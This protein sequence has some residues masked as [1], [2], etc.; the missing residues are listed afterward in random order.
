M[1]KIGNILHFINRVDEDNCGDRVVCPLLHYYDYFSQYRVMRHDMRFVDYDRITSGDVVIIGGGGMFNYAE[2][3]NR[4][5][6]RVLDTGATV[7]A[8]SPGFNTHT[9][10]CGTFKTEIDFE[11]FAFVTVRDFQNSYGLGYLPDVTCK[12]Q[13]LEKQY[14]IKREFG[15]ARHKDYPIK[16]LAF[17]TI[18]NDQKLEDILRFIGES[19]VVVS[20]SFHM[21]YWALLMGKRTI[22]AQP[23]S[24]K[25]YSYKYKPAYYDPQKDKL[26]DCVDQAQTYRILGECRA[27]ND[28]FFELVKRVVEEKLTP[29]RD[30]WYGYELITQEA[31]Q[32]EKFRETRLQ[33]GDLLASQLF[34]DTG[35]GF[36]E[37]CKLAS[38]N[39]V[40]GDGVHSVRF[41]LSAF[42]NIRALRFDPIESHHCE[43]EIRS[44]RA[45]TGD[46]IM[47]P[48]ASVRVGAWDRFL[49]TDP[50]YYIPA[51]CANF[52]EIKFCLRVTT[53]FEAEQ[54]IYDYVGRR[55]EAQRRLEELIEQRNSQIAEQTLRLEQQDSWIGELTK[56][57]GRLDMQLDDLT[58]ELGVRDARLS[59]M[60]TELEKRNAR[61]SSMETDLEMRNARISSLTDEVKARDAQLESLSEQ[62]FQE[63][64][65]AARQAEVIQQ[66]YHSRSWR[67]TAPFR[68]IV[69]FFRTFM[70]D[71]GEHGT[72]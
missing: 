65:C 11:R 25:F 33:D 48:Q 70:K 35:S 28:R 54:N 18:T 30:R 24:T 16:G 50:Q 49:S 45:E 67:L 64:T 60:E 55:D 58:A 52:L 57:L 19:E 56:H 41:D 34:I 29:V 36:S 66:L 20:N 2:F 38:I 69:N 37:S 6:N 42:D 26:Q 10:Y 61:L 4:A 1:L 32:R 44:A 7:L 53:L 17:D 71:G 3:T 5:I 27:E 68:A 72:G 46:V 51:P 59:S 9:E 22:C 8:W 31:L 23:F 14:G 62:L 13:G 12:L 21:I 39:N 63:H 47:Q 43:V 15:I 40:Y